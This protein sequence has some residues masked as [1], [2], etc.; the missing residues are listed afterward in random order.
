M[1]LDVKMLRAEVVALVADT[2]KKEGFSITREENENVIEFS[3]EFTA[4]NPYTKREISSIIMGRVSFDAY[5]RCLGH[6]DIVT[7]GTSSRDSL[8]RKQITQ[9]LLSLV[10]T[11][12][13]IEITDAQPPVIRSRPI[14][15]SEYCFGA[16]D[17]ESF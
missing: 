4:I 7:K 10:Q 14:T 6:A 13:E 11:V 2:L 16:A 5:A 15:Q 17:E 9:I 3:K 8:A 12:G 1:T